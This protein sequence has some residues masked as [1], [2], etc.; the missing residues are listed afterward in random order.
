MASLINKKHV[1]FDLDDTL[2]D[3]E[4]NS[5]RVLVDLFR[6]FSLDEKL[7]CDFDTFHHTYK[8]ENQT[9]WSLYYRKEIDKLYL[10]NHRFNR[11]F[12]L[13]GYDNYEENL[14]ISEQYLLR[15]PHGTVLKENC[16]PVL[17]YLQH[18]Y[19]LHII[20]NGFKEVQDIKLKASGIQTFFHQVIISEEHGLTKPDPAI[21]RLAEK[22]T[23]AEPNQC[24]MIGDNLE[25]DIAGAKNAGWDAIFFHENSSQAFNGHHIKNLIELKNFL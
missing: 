15:S 3:F 22:L 14:R 16:V 20:T 5:K 6:E 19:H 10:R 9:L 1:F 23:Q 13:F 25:S 11:A 17:R 18:H 7:H 24:V 4:Q 21:F 2:W 12:N 8:K